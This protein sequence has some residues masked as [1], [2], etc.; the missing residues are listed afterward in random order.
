LSFHKLGVRFALGKALGRDVQLP[1][2]Q[3]DSDAV[4]SPWVRI[5]MQ[6]LTGWK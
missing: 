3:A 5:T 1:S 2:L 4:I 6:I